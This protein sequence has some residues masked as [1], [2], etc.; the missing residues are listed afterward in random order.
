MGAVLGVDTSCYTTSCALANAA[1]LIGQRRRLLT[2]EMGGRGLMQS[3]GVFQH[4]GRLPALLEALLDEAGHPAVS[5]VCASTRPRPVEGSYMPVFTVGEGFARSVA[6]ALN[7]PFFATSHQE[8]HIRA[9][10]VGTRLGPG[11]RFLALHLSGGTT[12]IVRVDGGGIGLIGGSNDLHAGQ[13]VDRV[14]VRLGLPFP[15]GPELEKLARRGRAQAR[16]PIWVRGCQCSFSGSESAAQRLIDAGGIPPEDMAA[17]VFSCLARALAKTLWNAARETGEK[18]LLLA[19][20]VASAALLRELLPERLRRLGA[21]LELNWG[22][23]E[24]SGDNAG[25]VALIGYEKLTEET[26]HGNAD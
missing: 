12:E 20:G 14:G 10:M 8:G 24:L 3:E 26:N 7:V 11:D 19:G 25:G 5:A 2:V 18:K 1:G 23:P 13:F 16:L 9:A 21:D 4:V 22:R 6:A 15:A 17:E